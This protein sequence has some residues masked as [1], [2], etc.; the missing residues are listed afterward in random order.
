MTI[1]EL[2]SRVNLLEL[3]K[4]N[5][6]VKKV[7]RTYRVDPCP[8]CGR[9]DHFTVY[10]ETNSYSS[11]SGC[12][13]GGSVYKYL[14]EVQGLTEET[15]YEILKELAGYDSVSDNKT[16]ATPH[17][18][19][20]A[21]EGAPEPTNKN[22]Y[23]NWINELYHKQTEDDISYFLN[24]GIHPEIIEKYKL[25]IANTSDGKRAIL[26][27]W[28]N[29]EVVYYTSRAL[30]GQEPKYKN[31]K[32]EAPLFNIQ[33]LDTAEEGEVVI[34]TEGII[35]ALNLENE[36]FKAIALGGTQHAGKLLDAIKKNPKAKKLMLLT[37]FD[38]DE[39]G[40]MAR[41]KLKLK[42]LRIPKPYKDINEWY[43]EDFEEVKKNIEKQIENLKKPDN[44]F[45]YMSEKLIEDIEA[46]Q[47]FKDRKSGYE[48]LDKITSIYPG[49][50]VIGGLSSLGKTTFIHQMADQMAERGEHI[51]FFSLEMATLELISKSLSRLTTI[52]EK[53]YNFENAVSGIQ[54]RYNDIPNNKRPKVNE[55]ISNYENISKRFSIIEGN[56]N[57]DIDYIRQYVS[58]YILFNRVNPIVIIDYLQIIPGREQDRSDKERVDY[59]VTELKR[60][61]RDFNISVIVVSSLNRTNY[62]TPI[63]FESFKESGGIEY[64]ADVVWGLQLM[65]IHDPVF[66]NKN[67]TLKAKREVIN[68][69]KKANPREIELVCLKNRSGISVYSCAFD[70]YP[71]YD[72]FIPKENFNIDRI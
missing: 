1:K 54:I 62:L 10:P 23:T 68:T 15:A 2:E 30:K 44:L 72:L 51:L 39:A 45:V 22:N 24:R 55:A 38:N 50:Y 6:Q 47:K 65:A 17:A 69:A 11:F 21:N 9:K 56:F 3:I 41:K 19:T 32:G 49:L 48:N 61:S 27:I 29:G 43:V 14:Q 70:Y 58:D 53:G 18:P 64:T 60:M 52:D 4:D 67:A 25:C 28:E 59:V 46:Y 26:P 63:D 66:S 40:D 8:I 12:C 35:D 33:Y 20:K 57:T 42:N 31:A 13:T 37:A 36:G 7:G 16:S 5:Y 71:K 34:I